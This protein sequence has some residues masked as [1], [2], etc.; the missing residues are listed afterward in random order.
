MKPLIFQ[1]PKKSLQS[2]AICYLLIFCCNL[3]LLHGQESAPDNEAPKTNRPAASDVASE[4]II[5]NYL[6][7]TGGQEANRKLTHLLARG[8]LTE[9]GKSKTFEL[10][11]MQDGRRHLTL[12]WRHLGRDYKEFHVF[13]GS[14]TWQQQVKPVKEDPKEL[15]G[16]T[17]KHFA[18]QRWLLQPF[19]PPALTDYTFKY[20]GEARVGR[21]PCYVVVG[22]GVNDE[23]SWFYFDQEKFL[24][25]R[26]GGI[27]DLAGMQEYLDYRASRFKS[28]SGVLLPLEIDL[29]AEDSV[30]GRIEFEEILTN[31]KINSAVFNKPQGKTPLLRQ[32]PSQAE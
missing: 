5:R 3:T 8:R 12:S 27:G 22:Y 2:H 25:L 24:L 10:I 15:S 20:Q 11:E 1:T 14:E 23:R 32:R 6:V 16:P 26:W 13:N 31:Q 28:Q 17:G 4:Q 7:A 30:F 29:L 9:A 19:V 18:N 21:R